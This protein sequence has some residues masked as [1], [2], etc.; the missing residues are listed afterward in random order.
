[1]NEA[2][3]GDS[4]GHEDLSKPAEGIWIHA[5]CLS[6]LLAVPRDI[7]RERVNFGAYDPGAFLVR[8]AP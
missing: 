6:R 4:A 8:V 5:W 2:E 3:G 7:P 1:M